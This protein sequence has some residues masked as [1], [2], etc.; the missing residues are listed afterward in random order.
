MSHQR[1]K[2]KFFSLKTLDCGAILRGIAS[3]TRET[4]VNKAGKK[5]HSIKNKYTYQMFYKHLPIYLFGK[6]MP[7]KGLFFI[8]E[9][10]GAGEYPCISQELHVCLPGRGQVRTTALT[11]H[12]LS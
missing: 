7:I 3:G 12:S 8:R 11:R 1:P 6:Q 4:T 10:S 2:D 9:E 5:P